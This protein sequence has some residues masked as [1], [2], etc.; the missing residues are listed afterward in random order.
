MPDHSYTPPLMA[1]S[2][3]IAVFTIRDGEPHVVL[4]R[5]G[6]DPYKGTWAL[7]GGFVELDED[8]PV[9]ASRELAEETGLEVPSAALSQVAAYGAP[10]R[11]PRMRVVDILY[12]ANVANLADPVGASDA[13]HSQLVPVADATADDFELAF[14]HAVVLQDA[15]EASGL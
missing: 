1:V 11:D 5:R 10:D 15:V 12:W 2:V 7:P 9:A 8:L 6:N 3:D 14:D 4:I 13:A